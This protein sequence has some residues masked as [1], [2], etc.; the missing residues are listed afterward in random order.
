MVTVFIIKNVLGIVIN[1]I[2]TK[3]SN[4]VAADLTKQQFK[5]YINYSYQFYKNTNSN[6][7]TRDVGTI[8][9]EFSMGIILPMISLTSEAFVVILIGIGI[10][11]V[12]F[13]VFAIILAIFIPLLGYFYNKVKVKLAAYGEER[14]NTAPKTYKTIFEAIHGYV[15]VKLTNRENYFVQRCSKSI[16]RFYELLT[17]VYVLE[18]FPVRIIEMASIGFIGTLFAYFIITGRDREELVSFLLLFTVAAYR[19]MPSA[20]RIMTAILRIKNSSFILDIL[21]KEDPYKVKGPSYNPDNISELSFNESIELENI[22]FKYPEKYDDVLTD[23]SLTIKKKS[24]IGLIGS[25]GSGKTTL[26]NIILR[27]IDDHTGEVK[28]DGKTL[29]SENIPAWRNLIGYVQQDSYLLDASLAENIAFGF[30]MEEIDMDKLNDSIKQARLE[31][32]IEGL[33][34]GVDTN[35]GEFGGKISGGQRQRIAIAR[36]LYKNPKLLIFDEATSSLDSKVE[37]EILDT[38]QKLSD[39]G[40]TIISIAHRI[41]S[42]KFCD[43]I[44]ELSKGKIIHK[45][46]YAELVAKDQ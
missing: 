29:T 23:F 19:I 1:Y 43:E 33:P 26:V 18:L 4:G 46:T 37:S 28:V 38:I 3:F 21:E 10:L 13:K 35:V 9:T 36:A 30:P 24:S 11:T 12:D 25:S 8:P 32:F 2:Q 41:S 34:K 6:L 20:N 14:S 40:I 5:K 39:S 31:E 7:I 45:Y 27:L 22:G 15:D 42:L 17:K 16:H 44:Y